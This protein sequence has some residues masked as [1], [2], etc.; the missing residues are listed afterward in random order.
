MLCTQKSVPTPPQFLNSEYQML[1]PH[2]TVPDNR[3]IE[4]EPL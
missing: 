3:L 1:P 4:S 2:L